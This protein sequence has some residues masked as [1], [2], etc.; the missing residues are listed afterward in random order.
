MEVI[1][2]QPPPRPP[3]SSCCIAVVL[4]T[5]V[6]EDIADDDDD[7]SVAWCL[8]DEV[9]ALTREK[10]ALQNVTEEAPGSGNRHNES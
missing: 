10:R 7:T 4:P 3:S 5:L 6:R 2:S 1:H 8:Q 9:G